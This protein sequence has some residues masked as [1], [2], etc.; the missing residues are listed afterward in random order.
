MSIKRALLLVTKYK[1]HYN[2]PKNRQLE[3]K[4][5]YIVF[6]QQLNFF[7]FNLNSILASLVTYSDLKRL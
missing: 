6:Q 5:I 4:K 3:T 7:F 1:V 2:F